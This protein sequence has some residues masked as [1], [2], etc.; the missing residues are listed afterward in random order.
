[1]ASRESVIIG[2]T[3]KHLLAAL[4]RARFGLAPAARRRAVDAVVR[5]LL[6]H[7]QYDQLLL[8]VLYRLL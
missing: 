8:H 3:L 2:V 5:A 4:P 1:M 6:D 7:A